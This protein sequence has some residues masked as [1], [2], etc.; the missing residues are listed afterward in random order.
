MRPAI[1]RTQRIDSEPTVAGGCAKTLHLQD[2]GGVIL[3]AD[4][5]GVSITLMLTPMQTA[6][7][8]GILEARRALR[9]TA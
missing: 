5:N 6:E 9:R 4:T 7:L 3:T 1:I 8:A 2:D